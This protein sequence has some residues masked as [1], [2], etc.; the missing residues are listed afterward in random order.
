MCGIVALWNAGSADVA[1]T[2]LRTIAHRG[3]DDFAVEQVG[4][5]PGILGHSRLSII[6][7]DNGHQP[8]RDGGVAVVVNG[9]IYNHRE[10]RAILGPHRFQTD[11]DSEAVLQLFDAARRGTVGER[12]ID[13]LDGMFAFVL[14]DADKLIAVRDP[15]GIKPLYMAR[16]GEGL[17]FASEVKAFDG[18]AVEEVAAV[19]PGHLFD[20]RSG[21]RR[22][23]RMPHGAASAEAGLDVDG[24][25]RELR[26]VLQEAVR[27]W[28]MSDVGFGAFLSGGLDSSI[29]SALANRELNG[30]LRT[31][32]VGVDG[33]P[34][35]AAA[36]SVAAHIG[37][38]HHELR[39]TAEDIAGAFAEVI[40]HLESP[41]VDLVRSAV[42]T[43]FA[44][45]L[46]SRHVKVTLTG[47]GA[48]ELFAG[49]A[50]HKS[51]AGHPVALAQ[52][53][54]RSLGTMHN[55]NLQRVDRITMAQGL[56]A[57]TPFLDRDLI[58]FAQTIPADLK[59]R[60]GPSGEVVEKWILRT[61][62]EDLL[63]ADVVWRTKAQF[64]EGSGMVGSLQ[65]ALRLAIGVD[66]EVDRE[67]EGRFYRSLVTQ[68][69]ADPGRIF[70]TAGTWTSDR[71]VA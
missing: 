28:S 14:C 56:E 19:P 16:L 55:I 54:T 44:A 22:W 45:L 53:L 43:Y 6:G 47:E 11:S 46:A 50:Y 65:Q 13:R 9:E 66:D 51:Y 38:E 39:F 25:A 10:L 33:S 36:R 52:E 58:A 8:I 48:D 4:D 37:S 70:A 18:I 20:T 61:A 68:R 41:D 42:P 29:I 5:G 12:W 21:L 69:Y 49:Y 31:F 23:H 26:L 67:H 57:R 7:P 62:C 15:L 2:M 59:L 40:Y 17:A 60:Q 24:L 71:I 64:D 32:A 3:P 27:K 1:A 35:L 34:D 63:P 30:G